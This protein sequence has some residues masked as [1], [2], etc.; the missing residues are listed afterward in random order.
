MKRLISLLCI[1]VKKEI[2]KHRKLLSLLLMLSLLTSFGSPLIMHLSAATSSEIKSIEVADATIS[3]FN[4]NGVSQDG[5]F[6]YDFPIVCTVTMNDG[7]TKTFQDSE[8]IVI[9][10]IQYS[11]G[12]SSYQSWDEWQPGGTYTVNYKLFYPSGDFLT[13][14]DFQVTIEDTP[15]QSIEVE[16]VSIFE[17]SNG[18]YNEF[19]QHYK[20]SYYPEVTVIMKDGK[21]YTGSSSSIEIDGQ[22]YSIDFFESEPQYNEEWKTGKSYAVT[23]GIAGVTDVFNVS[24]TES[25]IESLEIEDVELL[26]KDLTS[27]YPDYGDTQSFYHYSISYT[28]KLKNGTVIKNDD[29]SIHINGEYYS[30][31]V[32]DNQKNESWE[33]GGAYTATAEIFGVEYP[34]YVKI[35]ENPKKVVDFQTEDAT[36]MYGLNDWR[37][38]NRMIQSPDDL[39]CTRDFTLTLADGTVLHSEMGS[40]LLDDYFNDLR[41]TY[42]WDTSEEDLWELG[43]TFT[44]TAFFQDFS[45]T[46]EITVVESCIESIDFAD[47]TL[48]ENANI[49]VESDYNSETQ[50]WEQYVRYEYYPAYTVTFKDGTKKT[51]DYPTGLSLSSLAVPTRGGM[52]GNF[53]YGSFPVCTDSQR[54]CPWEAGNTYT[55]SVSLFG[56][57]DTVN[58]TV[59]EN[60]VVSIVPDKMKVALKESDSYQYADWYRYSN[61]SKKLED[62]LSDP[63]YTV[64][65]KDGTVLRPT[66]SPAGSFVEIYNECYFVISS[67]DQ[68]LEPGSYNLPVTVSA[69]GE[70]YK[71]YVP[72]EVMTDKDFMK[73]LGVVDIE[74]EDTKVFAHTYDAFNPD[75]YNISPEF[76]FIMEDG[77]KSNLEEFFS[78]PPYFYLNIDLDYNEQQ[79]LKIGE[80]R[81]VTASCYGFTDEF[82]VTAIENPIEK[83]INP[84]IICVSPDKS[85]FADGIVLNENKEYSARDISYINT[86]PILFQLK[87]GTIVA[88]DAG[89]ITIY[90]N[91][92]VFANPSSSKKKID[93]KILGFDVSITFTDELVGIEVTPPNKVNYLLGETFEEDGLV[94]QNV[95]RN[96][97]KTETTGMYVIPNMQTVGDKEIIVTA[98]SFTDSFMIRISTKGDINADGKISLADVLAAA[99]AAVSNKQDPDSAEVIFGDVIGA[100]A[101]VTLADILKLARVSLGTDTFK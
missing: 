22:Y 49:R 68:Q 3:P 26:E 66:Q 87:D 18:Y 64:T 17:Y 100:D 36:L 98:N 13:D 5:Y 79:N 24:I 97:K 94:V 75:Y 9:N 74:I 46:F 38:Y 62:F 78:H 14:T 42:S 23:A 11:T 16:D 90:N 43:N 15:I 33:L 20:Y 40:I 96:G 54:E 81:T 71:L 89:Y 95:F 32:T 21:T 8:P 88:S 58:I 86:V 69:F 10:G 57:C 63:S 92:Y 41:P 35:V 50:T 65:L 7:T 28:A 99:R 25:P 45:D 82:K 80:V 44:V 19:W 56:F 37:G 53:A 2:V 67:Y 12:Y 70:E 34:F 4:T 61:D 27:F 47:V 60:P 83:V 6:D 84:D 72:T 55:A 93:T 1:G 101:K 48:I 85:D 91:K 52:G 29:N 31:N 30:L 73:S 39:I 76:D 51:F 77:S 59:I